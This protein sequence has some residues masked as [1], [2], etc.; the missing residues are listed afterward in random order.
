MEM[1]FPTATQTLQDIFPQ[2]KGKESAVETS[3][4]FAKN[5][6][7][8]VSTS[9]KKAKVLLQRLDVNQF[10]D[11]PSG[12]APSG[13]APTGDAPTGNAPSGDAATGDAPSGDAPT[14]NNPSRGDEG[15]SGT[16]TDAT[17][18]SPRKQNGI[19][20]CQGQADHVKK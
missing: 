13:D 15:T 20:G 14:G 4:T 11:A 18:S 17:P 10:G 8:N 7:Q 16:E 5:P 3:N 19:G 6:S 2:K 9:M 1:N 12:D